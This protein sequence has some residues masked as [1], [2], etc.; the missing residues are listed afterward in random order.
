VLPKQVVNIRRIPG[1]DTDVSHLRADEEQNQP[2]LVLIPPDCRRREAPDR[3]VSQRRRQPELLRPDHSQRQ[4][5]DRLARPRP[6]SKPR[7]P[8]AFD[9]I[10]R[11]DSQDIEEIEREILNMEY[12]EPNARH[13]GR[14]E[15]Q[16]PSL[17][18][19][20]NRQMINWQQPASQHSNNEGLGNGARVF[21]RANI[22]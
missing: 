7:N 15:C 19:L 9:L 22:A 20:G 16:E 8:R 21:E 4:Y 3:Q 11:E 6:K 18:I 2:D 5:P 14:L 10:P 12:E 17:E 1:K 13:L